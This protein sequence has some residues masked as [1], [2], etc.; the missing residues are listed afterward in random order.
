MAVGGFGVM[1]I[2][3]GFGFLVEILLLN[4]SRKHPGG[5]QQRYVKL[6]DQIAPGNCIDRHTKHPQQHSRAGDD[7]H[8]QS[9]AE[10]DD[11]GRAPNR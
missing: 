3:A 9:R 6:T 5:S 8:E 1:G 7:P 2:T 11:H 4:D 10:R